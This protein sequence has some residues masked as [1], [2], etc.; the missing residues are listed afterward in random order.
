MSSSLKEIFLDTSELEHPEPFE[1]STAIL[2]K[3][4]EGEY[5]RMLHR[6]V[7]YPLFEFCKDL[8]LSYE[9]REGS[10][11]AYEIIIYFKN[12]L[13]ALKEEGVL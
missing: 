10:S 2:V 13:D 3:L 8:S 9:L 1:L 7:P 11:T 12:D 4:R 6:K 5:Y